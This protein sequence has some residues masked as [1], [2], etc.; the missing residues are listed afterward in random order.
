MRLNAVGGRGSNSLD[1]IRAPEESRPPTRCMGG[2]GV[3]KLLPISSPKIWLM[4]LVYCSLVNKRVRATES[5]SSRSR[6]WLASRAHPT[7]NSK[8]TPTEQC[9]AN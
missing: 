6:G 4:L 3:S 9:F 5:A 8:A 2:M 1:G 7:S